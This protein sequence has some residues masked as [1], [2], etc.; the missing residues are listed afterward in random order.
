M[1]KLLEKAIGSSEFVIAVNLDIRG[2]SSFSM[3]VES[4]E[5]AVF[6]KKVYIKLIDEYFPT[7]SFFK[8]TGDGL[9]IIIPYTEETLKEVVNNTVSAC[10]K[11]LEDFGSFCFEDHMI[12]FEVP[13]KIGIGLSRGAACRIISKNK[14]LDYS[15]KVLNLA[16]RLMDMARPS[17][18]VFDTNFGIELFPQE[19]TTKFSKDNVYIKGIA[20]SEPLEIY[21]TK[22]LTNISPTNKEPIGKI[23]WR[24]VNDKKKF[25]M[26]KKTL[27]G[28]IYSLPS[29]PI[30]ANQIKI[31]ITI[32]KVI[33]G[34]IEKG[35]VSFLNFFDFEYSLL[36]EKPEVSV[37]YGK[38]A[39]LLSSYHIKDNWQI[40]IEIIYPEK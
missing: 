20:E 30:D 6:L 29:K 16:A 37:D 1:R 38:L 5:A 34:K 13:Q 23:N 12:N 19:I 40:E 7:A 2:F 25:K 11:V 15:G 28:Y 26:I 17:G 21:Y 24:S 14:T 10:L 9:F 32:P 18:I 4:S 39:A 33:N 35:L 3:K 22:D 36:A 31:K 8:P 27:A